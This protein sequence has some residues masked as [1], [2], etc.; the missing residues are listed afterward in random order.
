[1]SSTTSVS[2]VTINGQTYYIKLDMIANDTDLFKIILMSK[3]DENDGWMGTY[4][5]ETAQETLRLLYQTEDEYITNVKN[6]FLGKD[7]TQ[8][9]IHLI[10]NPNDATLTWKKGFENIFQE[11]GSVKLHRDCNGYKNA[12]VDFL[13]DDNNSL[14]I[15]NEKMEQQAEEIK[16]ELVLCKNELAR[17]VTTKIK[18][19]G[20]LYGKF[21]DLLNTKKQR[22][23]LLEEQLSN[24]MN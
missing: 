6:C 14:R 17:L 23:R 19:E 13:I 8:Y 18:A 2:K 4:P 11:Q 12:I 5:Y 9:Q 10:F 21:T 15:I 24:Y 7:S 16:N 3:D 1:M 22:I 20:N